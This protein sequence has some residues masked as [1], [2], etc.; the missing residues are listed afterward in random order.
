MFYRRSLVPTGRMLFEPYKNLGFA[1]RVL[2][3]RRS[4]VLTGG[5]LFEPYLAHK[6]VSFTGTFYFSGVSNLV[7]LTRGF[8][9]EITENTEKPS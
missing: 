1:T 7:G 4:L 9:T 8:T 3:Y 5:M 6:K 2:F